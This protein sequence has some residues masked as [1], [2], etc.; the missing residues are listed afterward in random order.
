MAR[1]E[2][3]ALPLDECDGSAVSAN[4][5]IHSFKTS[6]AKLREIRDQANSSLKKSLEDRA[7]RKLYDEEKKKDSVKRPAA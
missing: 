7:V 3:F 6:F 2:I 4:S 1:E 5:F